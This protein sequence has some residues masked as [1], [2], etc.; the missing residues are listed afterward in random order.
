MALADVSLGAARAGSLVV[1]V[2]IRARSL[3]AAE[4]LAAKITSADELVPR[5][6]FGVCTVGSAR[7]SLATADEGASQGVS[8]IRTAGAGTM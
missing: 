7:V 5:E 4:D 3:V 1:P 6:Q 8:T 2:R